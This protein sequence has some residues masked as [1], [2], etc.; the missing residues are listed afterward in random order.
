MPVDATI[1]FALQALDDC[2][3]ALVKLN[4]TCCDPGR[5]P[6]MTDLAE[7]ISHVRRLVGAASTDTNGAPDATHYIEQAGAQVGR[8]QVTC[9]AEDRLPLYVTILAGLT[10]T[11]LRLHAAIG[12]GH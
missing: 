10:A 6:Q 8:I 2:D 9:C 3:L 11:Q 12:H 1:D 4:E 7:T 5:S